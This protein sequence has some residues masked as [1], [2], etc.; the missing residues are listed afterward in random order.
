VLETEPLDE[1]TATA[2]APILEAA[3]LLTALGN[4]MAVS[5]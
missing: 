5:V 1:A 3:L 2:L 4:L